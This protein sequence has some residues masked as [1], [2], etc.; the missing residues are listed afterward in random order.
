MNATGPFRGGCCAHALALGLVLS[1]TLGL[2]GGEWPQFRGPIQGVSTDSLDKQWTGPI[3]NPVWRVALTNGLGSLVVGGGRVFTMAR[4]LV[5][6]GEREI[7]VALNA[8]NGA[9]LWATPVDIA[10]YPNGGVGFDDGPRSTPALEGGSVFVLSSYMKLLRLNATNGTVVWSNDL[11]ATFGGVGIDWQNSASPVIENGLIYVNLNTNLADSMT[12]L[13]A[14]RVSDGGLAWR[15]QNEPLTHATPVLAMMHGVRQVVFASQNALVSV[16]PT[17]GNQLWRL[18]YPFRFLASI[19][20]SPVVWNDLVFVCGA[21]AYGMSSIVARVSFSNSTWS[22]TRVWATNNPTSH[23]MT[24]VA[25]DGFLYGPF[26][27][28]SF[29]SPS[30]QLK[31]VDMRTGTVKW[32]TD[33]FGRGATVLWDDHL[34]T[35]TERGQLVLSQVSTNAYVELGRFTAIPGYHNSTNKC[36]NLPAIADGRIYIRST[37]FVACFDLSLPALRVDGPR[38]SGNGVDLS[39][40]TVTG[41]PV[42]SNRLTNLEVRATSDPTLVVTQW[43]RLTNSLVLTGGAV[44]VQGA[45]TGSETQRYFIV[46]E[47]K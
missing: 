13:A 25:R 10:S 8:T 22:A 24:P 47:P 32:S 40:R 28:Q 23:W 16:E 11:R 3:T 34:V 17:T 18:S 9:E 45:G 46:R 38:F 37:A 39:I 43:T 15:A 42:A 36:W 27:I 20:V 29:D 41:A 5:P 2:R 1:A 12:T 33:N 26:G 21:H 7:C 6:G 14:L 19:G 30:A 35:L 44:R 31:C 4:R